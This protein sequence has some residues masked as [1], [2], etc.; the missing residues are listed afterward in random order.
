MW[1]RSSS[2]RSSRSSRR[3]WRTTSSA[4]C[5]SRASVLPPFFA[6]LWAEALAADVFV[7]FE[8]AGL[9]NVEA[10]AVLGRRFRRTLLAPG[11]G[12]NPTEALRDFLG[13]TPSLAAFLRHAGL[14]GAGPGP[15]EPEGGD[16]RTDVYEQ[17]DDYVEFEEEA[18]D[19]P[20]DGDDAETGVPVP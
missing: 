3:A 9:D 11:S 14:E 16:G 8:S 20:D 2:R 4:A 7:E 15:E 10:V 1:W 5:P 6:E 17:D 18:E 19:D 12:R 13:R